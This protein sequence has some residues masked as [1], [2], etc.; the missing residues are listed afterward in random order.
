MFGSVLNTSLHILTFRLKYFLVEGAFDD[1]D[2][3]KL[4]NKNRN[5]GIINTSCLLRACYFGINKAVFLYGA[6]YWSRPNL[7]KN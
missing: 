3:V 2:R 5:M 4:K 1:C 6:T 7:I